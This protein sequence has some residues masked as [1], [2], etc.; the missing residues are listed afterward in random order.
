MLSD[1]MFGERVFSNDEIKLY[2][3]EWSEQW[4]GLEHYSVDC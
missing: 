3:Q 1:Y 4:G 2:Q